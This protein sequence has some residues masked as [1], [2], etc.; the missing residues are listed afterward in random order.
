MV[1]LKYHIIFFLCGFLAIC[2]SQESDRDLIRRYLIEKK[3]HEVIRASFQKCGCYNQLALWVI[4]SFTAAP[5]SER[6]ANVLEEF[7]DKFLVDKN[8]KS[9]TLFYTTRQDINKIIYNRKKEWSELRLEAVHRFAVFLHEMYLVNARQNTLH[10]RNRD[11]KALYD[12]LSQNKVP[13]CLKKIRAGNNYWLWLILAA[14]AAIFLFVV[15]YRFTKR[16]RIDV[17]TGKK[18]PPGRGNVVVKKTPNT[19]QHKPEQ[20]TNRPAVMPV[21]TYET[22]IEEQVKKTQMPLTTQK[23]APFSPQKSPSKLYLGLPQGNIFQKAYETPSDYETFFVLTIDPFN[24]DTG[25]FMLTAHKETLEYMLSTSDSI[26]G[27]CLF[28][29]KIPTNPNQLIIQS[30]GFAKLV[31]GL[32]RIEKKIIIKN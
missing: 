18:V 15:V 32:W 29:G 6:F 26:L 14:L 2:N 21:P 22:V 20:K 28:E 5:T 30:P 12:T 10:I 23:A 11:G 1:K 7:E 4:D 24:K 17:A 27:T 9:W 31:N 3:T 19:D 16:I 13:E 8:T 25:T